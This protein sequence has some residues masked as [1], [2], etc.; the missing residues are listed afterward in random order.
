MREIFSKKKLGKMNFSRK[1]AC[2]FSASLLCS[3]QVPLVLA[4]DSASLDA[5]ELVRSMSQAL[6]QLNYEGTFV[7][8]S[9]GNI[10]TMRILHSRDDDGEHER[11]IS[12]NGEAREVFRNNK[13]VTCVWPGSKSVLVSKSKPRDLI[14]QVKQSLLDSEF[15]SLNMGEPDRV[16][17]R[18]THVVHIDPTDDDRYGYR[19]W[20]DSESN[21]LLRMVLLDENDQTLEQ[22]MFTDISYP[23]TIDPSKLQA[24]ITDDTFTWQEPRPGETQ[25]GGAAY[26]SNKKPLKV[27]EFK[28]LPGGYRKVAETYDAMPMTNS[29]L[30]HVTLSDGIASV[31][32]Y[33][34]YMPAEHHDAGSSGLS[35]MGAMNAYGRG[36]KTAFV[37]VVGEVPGGVVKTIGES[38]ILSDQTH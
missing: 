8:M 24:N 26:G 33:V 23:D 25:A 1:A 27:V 9:N 31:S 13:T 5:R 21:M 18:Q 37:T 20:I 4:G 12:L 29:P 3:A 32:V 16:A 14:P 7:H 2:L 19:Y 17:G 36:L 30:S 28:S 11:M 35:R 6:K 38:V 22:M 34:E 10:E 15:Y